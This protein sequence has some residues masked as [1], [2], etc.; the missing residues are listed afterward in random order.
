M[1]SPFS[2]IISGGDFDFLYP[3]YVNRYLRVPFGPTKAD[4]PG[5]TLDDAPLIPEV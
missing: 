3:L 2:G 5:G 4:P 1:V